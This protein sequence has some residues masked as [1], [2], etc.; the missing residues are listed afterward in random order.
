MAYTIVLGT[1]RRKPSEFESLHPYQSFASLVE[2]V[3]TAASKSA[4]ARHTSSNLV[5]GT[6]YGYMSEWT[7]LAHC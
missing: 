3:Y 7:K 5:I 2:L 6:K 1:I 4:A